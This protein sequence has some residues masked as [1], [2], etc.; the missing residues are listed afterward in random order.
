VSRPITLRFRVAAWLGQR[1]WGRRLLT[2]FYPLSWGTSDDDWREI[3]ASAQASRR[4]S[5]HHAYMAFVFR[6]PRRGE[7]P[8]TH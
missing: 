8:A 6:K 2:L 4:L 3:E 1:S 7:K 5:R